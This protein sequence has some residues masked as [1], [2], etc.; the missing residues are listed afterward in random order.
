[1]L[2]FGLSD[3]YHEDN[4]SDGYL[5]K[6]QEEW[7]FNH[8]TGAV[9][10]NKRATQTWL[11][12]LCIQSLSAPFRN[13]ARRYHGR[14]HTSFQVRPAALSLF[15]R[16]FIFCAMAGIHTSVLLLGLLGHLWAPLGLLLRVGL[17]QPEG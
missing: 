6:T 17:S 14:E 12:V 15:L 13:A 4:V 10:R 8:D 9:L 5:L 11:F 3:T 1:M 16:V 2:S 7:R